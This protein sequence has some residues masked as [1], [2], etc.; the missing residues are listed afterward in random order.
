MPTLKCKRVRFYS[1][2]D[3]SAFFAFARSITAVKR[4][5]GARD[6]ILLHIASRP[7]QR[8]LRD[9]NALFVRYRISGKQQLAQLADRR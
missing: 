4:I 5:E 8:S 6:S 9:L 3:E 7:S 2:G 1:E